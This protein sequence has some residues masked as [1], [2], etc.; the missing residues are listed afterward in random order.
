ML[1]VHREFGQTRPPSANDLPP[2]RPAAAAHTH[3][4]DRHGRQGDANGKPHWA[5]DGVGTQHLY[6]APNAKRQWLLRNKF[7]PDEPACSGYHEGDDLRA[8]PSDFQWADVGAWKTSSLIVT[9]ADDEKIWNDL[10]PPPVPSASDAALD[11]HLKATEAR[12]QRANELK[13]QKRRPINVGRF[14]AYPLRNWVHPPGE[15][16]AP[17][18]GYAIEWQKGNPSTQVHKQSSP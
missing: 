7:T 12:V 10:P 11:A 3:R 17:R 1:P 15:D 18:N 14:L 8:G 16:P 6:Y 5:S 4:A 9:Q 2:E 13:E